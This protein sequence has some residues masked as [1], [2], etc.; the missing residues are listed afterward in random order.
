M[1]VNTCNPPCTS[2]Y[3]S[4]FLLY[5]SRQQACHVCTC[6]FTDQPSTL[7]RTQLETDSKRCTD[8]HGPFQQLSRKVHFIQ[9]YF[10]FQYTVLIWTSSVTGALQSSKNEPH[11]IQMLRFEVPEW[12]DKNKICSA[13]LS[14][15]KVVCMK[16][17]MQLFPLW[18]A[19]TSFVKVHSYYV[20]SSSGLCN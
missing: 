19:T 3:M 10:I 18:C 8:I 1:R 20:S 14:P 12:I 16:C 4:S 9:Y 15:D 17:S 6:S 11:P 13:E 2:T 5:V 7:R